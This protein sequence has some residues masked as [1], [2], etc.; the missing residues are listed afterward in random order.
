MDVFVPVF[1][2]SNDCIWL[3]TTIL[4]LKRPILWPA[5][6]GQQRGVAR[7]AL[8]VRD[9]GAMQIGAFSQFL[10][11]DSKAVPE[12]PHGRSKTCDDS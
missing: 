4:R 10:L 11:R 9:I 6:Y 3:P 7:A 12:L 2:S 5:F 1:L 8:N